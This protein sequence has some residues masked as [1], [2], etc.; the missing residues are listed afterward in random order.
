MNVKLPLI[1]KYCL[2]VHFCYN[3][4]HVI[5]PNLT[6]GKKESKEKERETRQIER[7]DWRKQ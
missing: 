5:V 6:G 1:P 2:F 3:T 7:K 4:F